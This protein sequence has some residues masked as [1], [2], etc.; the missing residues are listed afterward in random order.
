MSGNLNLIGE[1]I[2]E[3]RLDILKEST[4]LRMEEEP[5]LVE[6]MMSRRLVSMTQ[7]ESQEFAATFITYLGES[8]FSDENVYFNL[9]T[10]WGKKAGQLGVNEGIPLEESLDGLRFFRKAILNTIKK[11]ANG[12]DVLTIDDVLDA[13]AIIDP[14]IDRCIYC[15]SLAHLDNHY[16][17]LSKAHAKVQ[18]LQMPIVPISD[19]IAVL[20]IIGELDEDRSQYI[21]EKA[22][23]ESSRLKLRHLIID[24]SGIVII[25]T[26]V[27][28]NMFRVVNALKLLGVDSII[29]GM[30]AELTQTVVS[31]GIDFKDISTFSNLQKAL[32]S[33]G[34]SQHV[35]KN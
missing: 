18:E 35:V 32:E 25:D 19:G 24:L 28:N 33:I 5:E 12:T 22:L 13:C 29:T 9:I 31:L 34:F 17:T 1:K 6:K 2:I 7:E 21:L 8:L 16:E 3:N 4:A 27:A 10:E 15:F 11:Q 26:M 14:L 30:R 23:E 20:P